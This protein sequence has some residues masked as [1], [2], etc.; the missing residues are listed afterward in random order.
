MIAQELQRPIHIY[1][2]VDGSEHS[3]A[4]VDLLRDLPINQSREAGSTITVLA[5]L[6]IRHT[7]SPRRPAGQLWIRHRTFCK[8]QG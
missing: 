2:A 1:L 8:A 6:T 7:V 3:L 5:V 4:A